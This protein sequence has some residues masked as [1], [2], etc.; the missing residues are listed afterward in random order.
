M[1]TIFGKVGPDVQQ[2]WADVLEEF[3]PDLHSA[4]LTADLL[5][6]ESDNDNP[7]I[8]VHGDP[9]EACIK[10]NGLDQ[11][12]RGLADVLV[13]IDK[14][15][16]D[17]LDEEERRALL[18]HEAH[19]V[20]LKRDKQ[21]NAVMLDDHGRPKVKLRRHDAT[22]GLFRCVL[23]KFADKSPE[24]RQIEEMNATLSQKVFQF[25]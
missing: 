5:Y 12:V 9:A 20:E 11:R 18:W 16:W 4:S 10:V 25:A 22:L 2:I 15:N 24:H 1:A 14:T 13:K 8:R 3:E 23:D 6:A 17:L 19:H 7:A 21:T